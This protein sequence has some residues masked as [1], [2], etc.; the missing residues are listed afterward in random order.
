ML[1]EEFSAVF[2]STSEPTDGHGAPADQFK[3]ICN[4]YVFNTVVTRAQSLIVVAGN[5]FFLLP[6]SRPT[7][8]RSTF[9]AASNASPLNYQDIMHLLMFKICQKSL[10]KYVRKCFT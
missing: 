1:G 6:T 7:A 8:G 4:E 9:I 3:S 10:V 5:P 2:L